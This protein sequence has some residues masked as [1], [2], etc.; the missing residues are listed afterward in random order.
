MPSSRKEAEAMTNHLQSGEREVDDLT[1][2]QVVAAVAA[3]P[4][5]VFRAL[6]SPD[7]TDW[8]VRPGVFDT[9][10]WTGDVRV[11]GHWQASGVGRGNPYAL[12]GE[13]LEVDP[14]GK[15]V[16]TWHSVGAPGAPTT[17]T[18]MLEPLADGTRITLSHSGFTSPEA[19]T[20][21]RIGWETSF[22]QL[23]EFLAAEMR[24]DR[25]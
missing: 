25:G 6:T 18:Y 23:R 8:W 22:D 15:L 19:C 11:G 21:T 12:E 1:E 20:N 9:R 17:V 4:E 3:P 10:E 24:T 13:F 14:P 2:G 16:H 7:V 5:R